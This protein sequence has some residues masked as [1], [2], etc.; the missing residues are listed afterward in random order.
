M[1]IVIKLGLLS[2]FAL[3]SL[4]ALSING[5][6]QVLRRSSRTTRRNCTSWNLQAP[7]KAGRRDRKG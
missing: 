5:R 7:M 4:L 2:F 1:N 6:K 3:G